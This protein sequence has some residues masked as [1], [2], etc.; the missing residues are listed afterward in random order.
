MKKSNILIPAIA[1]IAFGVF[2]IGCNTPTQPA[3][4]QKPVENTG[5]EGNAPKEITMPLEEYSEDTEDAYRAVGVAEDFDYAL[6]REMAR[7]DA[8]NQ[9]LQK[10]ETT[11]KRVAENYAKSSRIDNRVSS[12]REYE[13]LSRSFSEQKLVGTKQIK[14]KSFKNPKSG[15]Y[16]TYIAMELSREQVKTLLE[17]AHTSALSPDERKRLTEDREKFKKSQKEFSDSVDQVITTEAKAASLNKGKGAR[18]TAS[19]DDLF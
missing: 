11:M 9:I 12:Q 3:V 7:D 1:T 4:L 16:Q 19:A 10:I 15:T 13:S 2:L 5:S 6:A 17:K 14:Q 18:A 8:M